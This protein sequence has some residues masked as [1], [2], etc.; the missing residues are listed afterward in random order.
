MD[1]PVQDDN[2]MSFSKIKYIFY[3]HF[4]MQILSGR[5]LKSLHYIK[6]ILRHNFDD[7]P[8]LAIIETTN[9]CNLDC[10]TCPTPRHK[11]SR[12]PQVMNFDNFKKIIDNIKNHAHIILLYNT[13]EPLLHPELPKMIKY[14]DDNNLY[15]MISTN[16]TLL[17]KEKTKELLDAGLDEILLCLDGTSKKVYE[18]FRKGANFETVAKNIN[19]FCK[20]KQKCELDRPYIELQFILNRLNQDQ[21]SEI[22]K[23]AK[24]WNVNR[25]RIKSF[26]LC[27]YAYSTE[28]RKI[29][30]EKFL[31]TKKRDDG[32]EKKNI[33]EKKGDSFEIKRKSQ[34]CNLAKVQIA[35][36][37]DGSMVMCCYDIKGN[38]VYG[39]LLNQTFEEIWFDEKNIK[40]RK[41]AINKKFPLCK[42]CGE[43]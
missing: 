43:Y 41:L 39:N 3:R 25:L 33:F 28:E 40:R 6:I 31:T 36:L 2:I 34:D 20:E 26:T 30:Y 18:E 16:A 23:W 11:L 9:T 32:Y 13:N 37:V 7:A 19:H 42:I 35:V 4:W 29:L 17:N 38:Y 24:I 15:T 10:P 8:Y 12:N 1:L 5:L 21:I 27:E 14:C 22:K